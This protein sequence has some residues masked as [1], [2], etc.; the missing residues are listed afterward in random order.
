MMIDYIT[1]TYHWDRV[2]YNTR[3]LSETVFQAFI[4]TPLP[5][6]QSTCKPESEIS[7]GW[8]FLH[9]PGERER[10]GGFRGTV[11]VG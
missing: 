2:P 5:P 1:N 6:Q 3:L 11:G 9:H 8:L 10:V 7:G 4:S